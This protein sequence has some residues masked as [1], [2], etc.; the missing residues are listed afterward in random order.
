MP[1]EGTRKRNSSAKK[2]F[3]STGSSDRLRRRAAGR[4]HGMMKQTRKC[5]EQKQGV[6]VVGAA[7]LPRVKEMLG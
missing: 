5:R 6:K 4:S 2:R 1:K 3:R 7:D